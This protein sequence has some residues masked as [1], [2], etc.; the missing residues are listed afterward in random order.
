MSLRGDLRTVALSVHAPDVRLLCP[1]T[2]SHS[3]LALCARPSPRDPVLEAQAEEE[4][5]ARKAGLVLQ[6][7]IEDLDTSLG[8]QDSSATSTA[9]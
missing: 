7:K 8:P 1:V 3:S 6:L 9:P 5:A 2:A 4:Q